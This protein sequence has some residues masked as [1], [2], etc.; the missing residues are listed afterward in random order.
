MCFIF[1]EDS[2]DLME[3]SNP[4]CLE[5][6]HTVMPSFNYDGFPKLGYKIL[7]WRHHLE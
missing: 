6:I 7:Q 3:I 5:F 1:C 4:I 2:S